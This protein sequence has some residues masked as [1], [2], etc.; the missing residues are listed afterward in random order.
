MSAEVGNIAVRVGA[1]IQDLRQGMAAGSREVGSFAASSGKRLRSVVNDLVKVGAAAAAVA[2]GGLLAITK[3]ATETGREMQN[4]I[5]VANAG[6]AEFQRMAFGAQALG[7]E[8]DKLA[9]ILKD[10]N[11]RVGDF[12]QTGGG[13]MADFFEKIGPKVGVTA[14]QFRN[15]SGPQALQLY[16]TSLE[17]ANVNQ[18]DMTFYLEAMAGDLTKLQPLLAN[19]G[20]QLNQ[21]GDRAERLGLVLSDID[22]IQLE[23]GAQ[24]FSE[25]NGLIKNAGMLIGTN[26]IPYVDEFISR[27]TDMT[28]EAGGF[29]T[30]IEDVVNT[31]LRGFGKFGD[32]LHGNHVAAKTLAFAFQGLGTG[33]IGV[34]SLITEGWTRL[35]DMILSGI[36][37]V[38]DAANNIPGVDIPTDGLVDFRRQVRASAEAQVGLRDTMVSSLKQTGRE[39]HE[40]AMQDMPSK[41]IDKFLAD[42]SERADRA[43]Q[44]VLEARNKMQSEAGSTGGDQPPVVPGAPEGQQGDDHSTMDN[45][46]AR[47]QD[48]FKTEGE[49]L[50]EKLATE[51]ELINAGL[52]AKRISEADH[53]TLSEELLAEHENKMLELQKQAKDKEVALEEAKAQAKKQ[54]LASALSGMSTLMN[55]ES[56]KMFEIGKAAALTQAGLNAYEAISGAYKVGANIGGPVLGALYGGAAGLAQFQTLNSIRKQQFGSGGGAAGSATQQINGNTTPVGGGTAQAQQQDRV[57]RVEGVDPSSLFTGG[58]VRALSNAIDEFKSDGGGKVV[59]A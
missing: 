31:G 54:A 21:M 11:D 12:V 6:S 1:D 57:M 25:L 19:N 59:F 2:A 35:F 32:V 26:L 33:I 49:L 3:Q 45:E 44:E 34:A 16:Y 7:V 38:V 18:Q 8:Q 27:F 46:L 55:S 24:S 17:K 50:A 28:A 40:L 41:K 13:P 58:T 30:M 36:Q 43:A 42:V 37:G 5:R 56:R 4:M 51:Q 14:A 9:D 48:R 29:R 23:K 47:L 20:E 52:E 53:Y 15:L 39:L 22:L 10:V